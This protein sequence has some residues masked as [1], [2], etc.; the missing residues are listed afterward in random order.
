M[1]DRKSLLSIA[2]DLHLPWTVEDHNSYGVKRSE[3][4]DAGRTVV[5]DH[6]S[7]FAARFIVEAVNRAAG[8][9]G[10]PIKP[11]FKVGDVVRVVAPLDDGGVAFGHFI[12]P[13]PMHWVGQRAIVAD[14][15]DNTY[16]IYLAS[17]GP[18][19]YLAW[20]EEKRLAP[21]NER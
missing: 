10:R 11:K 8:G 9:Y 21:V 5:L 17:E 16:G 6:L 18:K 12:K 13:S 3:I 15:M 19:S 2:D 4:L 20:W 14:V 1:K 7:P